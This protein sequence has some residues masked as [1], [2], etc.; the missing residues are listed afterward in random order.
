[1]RFTSRCGC[2][3]EVS[4]RQRRGK[5]SRTSCGPFRRARAALS[6]SG[7]N[8]PIRAI[9]AVLHFPRRYPGS[10]ARRHFLLGW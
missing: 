1:L 2:S 4:P 10:V 5:R 8:G 7:L 3:S 6:I 9:A